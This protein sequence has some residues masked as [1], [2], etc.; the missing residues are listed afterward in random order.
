VLGEQLEV[1]VASSPPYPEKGSSSGVMRGAS[2]TSC[3]WW[4]STWNRRAA[5]AEPLVD[6]GNVYLP[7]PT[8]PN[9]MPVPGREWVPDFTGQLTAFPHAAHD[10]DLD[11]FTQLVARWR[12]RRGLTDAM[13]RV[14]F[15]V[16]ESDDDIE[17]SSRRHWPDF[18]T[19]GESARARNEGNA[20][21]VRTG[22]PQNEPYRVSRPML[23]R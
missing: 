22:T 6:A 16:N 20:A 18:W 15:G 14:I 8:A 7:R 5:A 13:R 19:G 1:P 23:D 21:P 9:G 2:M 12:R 3:L 17:E 11:A 10:D 4:R